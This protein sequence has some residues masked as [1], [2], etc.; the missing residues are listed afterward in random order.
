MTVAKPYNTDE[1]RKERMRQTPEAIGIFEATIGIASG[2]NWHEGQVPT[3]HSRGVCFP[4][5]SKPDVQETTS[6]E[7][8]SQCVLGGTRIVLNELNWSDLDNARWE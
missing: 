4:S 7:P 2:F 6:N 5:P 8:R 3:R 1:I